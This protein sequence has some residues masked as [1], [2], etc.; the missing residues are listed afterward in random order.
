MQTMS[1]WHFHPLQENGKTKTNASLGAG[2][3]LAGGCPWGSQMGIYVT[4]MGLAAEE[5]AGNMALRWKPHSQPATARPSS[6]SL[7]L[8]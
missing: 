1:G 6:N 8:S 2:Q 7:I 5:G 4:S 3:G